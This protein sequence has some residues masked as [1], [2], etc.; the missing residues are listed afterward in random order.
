MRRIWQ[1]G[2]MITAFFLFVYMFPFSLTQPTK[3]TIIFF[4][5]DPTVRFTKATT[6]LKLQPPK[7]NG[8]YPLL[9]MVSSTL[10]RQ[11]YLRQD[12]SLLFAD[13]RLVGTLSEWKQ[14]SQTLLQK[15]D[16]RTKDSHFFQAISF[17]YG[18]IH[19]GSTIGSS[20]KM[21]GDQLYVIDSPYSPLTS[22]RRPRTSEEKEWQSVLTKTTNESLQYTA[23]TLFNHFSIQEKNYYHLYLPELI[24][25]NEQPFPD[26]SFEKTQEIIGKLWEGLY[27]NYFLGIKREDGSVIS[28]IG[29]TV[30]LILLSKDY[31]HL[32]VLTETKN[33]E[34]IQLVQTIS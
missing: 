32:I 29:S 20:Q 25:Y 12:I 9:W 31:S 22:F 7:Q 24:V 27:R 16:V 4:P 14:N 23:E 34:K 8:K 21:S 5:L 28:P 11:V 15:K 33:G 18:E 26:L 17:H 1:I 6:N 30:P 13:G 2:T 3:E 10:D 19:K